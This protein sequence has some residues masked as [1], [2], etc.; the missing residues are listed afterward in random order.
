MLPGTEV[1]SS[2]GKAE[3]NF[4]PLGNG[5]GV[6]FGYRF[7]ELDKF[8]VWGELGYLSLEVKSGTKD[9]ILDSWDLGGVSIMLRMTF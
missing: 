9:G 3:A 5:Y 6:F 8:S 2:W 1:Y 4:E 7:W